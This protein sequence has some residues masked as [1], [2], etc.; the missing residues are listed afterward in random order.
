MTSAE[1]TKN[2]GK[3]DETIVI[4]HRVTTDEA[5]GRTREAWTCRLPDGTYTLTFAGTKLEKTEVTPAR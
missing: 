4:S 5:V 2:A 3:P 1:V